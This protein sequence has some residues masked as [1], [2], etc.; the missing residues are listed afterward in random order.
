VADFV[1]ELREFNV[2]P[3]VAPNISGRRPTIDG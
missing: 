1:M 3:Y 2:T